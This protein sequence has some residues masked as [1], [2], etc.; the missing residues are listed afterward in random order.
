[1]NLSTHV[2]RGTLS[3][4]SRKWSTNPWRPFTVHSFLLSRSPMR[5]A[6]TDFQ[7]SSHRLASTHVLTA[8]CDGRKERTWWSTV[9]GR[10]PMWSASVGKGSSIP[11]FPVGISSNRPR[12]L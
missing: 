3:R 11:S 4:S 1:M 6:V 10:A 12:A 8:S 9:S 7:R 2:W 5:N